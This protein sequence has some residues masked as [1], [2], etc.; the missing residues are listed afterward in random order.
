LVAKAASGSDWMT[1]MTIVTF[2]PVMV[3]S[4]EIGINVGSNANFTDKDGRV[5][6]ADQPY[7][8][9]RWGY[10]GERAKQ[11]YS[12]PTDRNI[13]GTDSDPLFQ[14]MV[15]GLTSYKFDVPNGVYEVELLFAETKFAE[16][17][18][19][20]FAVSINGEVLI[21][22]LDL[23]GIAGRDRAVTKTF[24][25]NSKD[26]VSITFT[27]HSGEPLVSGLRLTRRRPA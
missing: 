11:I 9:G 14:T 1:D 13:L 10:L 15:E 7:S 23:A 6:L 26:G 25:V 4:N 8:A 19:R 21:D 12:A 5:W 27:K 17:G 22:K 20:V 16:A 18:R 3:T 2:N 24:L